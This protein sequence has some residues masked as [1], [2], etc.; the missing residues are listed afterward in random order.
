MMEKKDYIDIGD[1][2]KNYSFGY[3]SQNS[4]VDNSRLVLIRSESDEISRDGGDSVKT[5]LVL[6]DLENGSERVIAEDVNNWFDYAVY[7]ELVYYVKNGELRVLNI[8]TGA[9]KTLF[10]KQGISMPHLTND[11]KFIS[12]FHCTPEKSTFFRVDSESAAYEELLEIAFEEPFPYA[13]HGM[14]CPMNPDMLFFSH[15][16]DT[17]RVSD[18]LWIYDKEK[19]EARNIAK[20]RR[21]ESGE[22]LDCYGHECWAHERCGLY[23]VRYNESLAPS[24]ICYVNVDTG[25]AELLYSG[26]D[27]WHVSAS[28]DDKY[29]AGDTR[30]LGGNT[31]GV[32]V[33]DRE[34]REEKLVDKVKTSFRHPCHP[35]PAFSPDNLKLIYHI[36]NEHGKCSVRIRFLG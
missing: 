31:S 9:V 3:Y 18:R 35:H 8:N 13:N 12:V 30:N 4:W 21:S 17:K 34:G 33:I 2:Q 23:F 16:G 6:Y 36:L 28:S 29:L 5:E 27:Y 15:E 22:V 32:I 19:N 7:G 20:Q 26:Y 14:I 11:G 10:S 24:G 1:R 25:N